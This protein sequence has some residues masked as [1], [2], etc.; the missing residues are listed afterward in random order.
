MTGDKKWQSCFNWPASE[1]RRRDKWFPVWAER[2]AAGTARRHKQSICIQLKLQ[3]RRSRGMMGNVIYP[4]GVTDLMSAFSV[5][6]GR[7]T[8]FQ[9]WIK[10]KLW[11]LFD[12]EA[13][14][15]GYYQAAAE[16][17]IFWVWRK[18]REIYAAWDL[19]RSDIRP[20]KLNRWYAKWMD[21]LSNEFT[22]GTA[23]Q[24]LRKVNG[25]FQ[26][27]IIPSKLPA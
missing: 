4:Q 16:I 1:R 5:S 18:R 26:Q 2:G 17:T 13:Q 20:G 15:E 9:H 8:R 12:S 10:W 3:Q 27:Q 21:L 7:V 19:R 25:D 22:V 11:N 6:Q 23:I 14:H 24:W